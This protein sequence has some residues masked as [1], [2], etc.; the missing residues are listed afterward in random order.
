MQMQLFET[1]TPEQAEKLQKKA[2][3]LEQLVLLLPVYYPPDKFC[4]PTSQVEGKEPIPQD[5]WDK[6]VEH[7]KE[8]TAI[9]KK[10]E[11]TYQF[12]NR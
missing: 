11:E 6:T 1:L 9:R 3:E 8:A 5:V 10:L 7:A 4:K 12:K 2:H